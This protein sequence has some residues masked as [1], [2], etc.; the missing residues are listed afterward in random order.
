MRLKL[1]QFALFLV[2]ISLFPLDV[3]SQI[4]KD[5]E[6]FVGVLKGKVRD[7]V[8]LKPIEYVQIKLLSAIDSS[9]VSGIYSNE[10]GEFELT[11]LP[12]RQFIVKLF[13]L[14]YSTKFI[15]NISIS[16]KQ[17]KID[18][19]DIN[20]ISENQ[21][22]LEE[23]KVIGKLDVFK[24]GIDKKVFNVAE[25]LS[26]KGGT[27][28]DVL[29][30]IPSVGVDQDG[31]ISLRGD[32]NVTILIDGRPSSFSGGNG[33]SLLDAIPASS[34]ERIEI[35]TNP[36][37]S[38]SPD[39][40][41]GIINVVLKK[42]KLRGT[43][44]MISSTGA[45]GNLFNGSASFS[46]R[47]SKLNTYVNYTYRYSEG[48]RNNYGKLEQVSSNNVT[49]LLDQNRTGGDLNTGHTVRFGTDFYVKSNQ[50][51]GFSV[52]GND[53]IRN[54][55]GD[56]KNNLYDGNSNLIKTWNRISSD[57]TSQQNMDL[58]LNY[59]IDFKNDKG[60]LTTDINQSLGTDNIKGF[61]DEKYLNLDGTPSSKMDLNQQ[62]FNLEKNNVS[63]AQMD[64]SRTFSKSNSRFEAGVKS[65]VRNLGVDTRSE[66]LDTTTNLFNPDTLANFIYKYNEQV[67]SAYGIL[68]QQ[69]GK[70]KYQ[71]G[72][73]LEQAIQT[74]YLVSSN[75]KFLN[76]YFNIYPSGHIKYNKKQNTEWSLSY[77]RRINR[78]SSS[79]MNPFTNFSDP[80]NLRM[81][82]PNLK[83]E[84]I[85]SFDLGYSIEKSKLTITSSIYVRQTSDVIQ[86]IKI[87][88][89]DNTSAVTFANIDK[90]QSA[91][92]EIVAVYKPVKWWK[93]VI[94]VNGSGIKYTDNTVNFNYNNSGFTWGFKYI[95]S[96]D[97]W[98][99]SM[100]AQ[101]NVNYIAPM[102]TAQGKAQRRGSIDFSTEKSLKE[103]KWSVGI[104]VTDIFDKQGFSFRVVQPSIIQ[105]SEYKWLT[106]RLYFTVSYKFGK[107]EIPHKKNV[108]DGGGM[109]Y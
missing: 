58:N 47:N 76:N 12:S 19:G 80:F 29:N 69:K 61:Y 91:G 2:I 42:N 33:K 39:G 81:G 72:V 16:Q 25:D 27:A 104:R 4:V 37:A 75:Q 48:Y 92:V 94:S 82:N 74:P 34:I 26:S 63:T 100:T 79:D 85:N 73:R 55:T 11:K 107:L 51:I 40:T 62:L 20:L 68:G 65:I 102:I 103:G 22:G 3:H 109:D 99:K 24:T 7:S 1:V 101:L 28:N 14:G 87:Y 70:F 17:N 67:Y 44:G 57:P 21:V 5:N 45:T 96:I 13:F 56:L 46:F 64:Y 18:L 38:Y 35:I 10:K 30:K 43:N 71:V 95:S 50:T 108:N 9:V 32:G 23:V 77:S 8:S 66:M 84:Y 41:S 88:N 90:S 49:S 15:S 86:R 106:R 98:K 93:N 54:R 97:F 53:G 60:T 52:T 89:E 105:T 36:S 59:K 31:K 83:P 78:A 6:T